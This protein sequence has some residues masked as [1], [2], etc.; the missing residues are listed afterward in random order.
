MTSPDRAGRSVG[1]TDGPGPAEPRPEHNLRRALAAGTLAALLGAA[2]IT[3]AAGLL[4][5]TAG[6]LVVALAIGRAVGLVVAAANG[7]G[8]RSVA[9]ALALALASVA[10]GQLGTWLV[11]RAEGGVLDL[12]PYLAETFGIL[13]P[14]ELA[15]AALAAWW[16]AR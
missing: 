2:A 12:G 11:A 6:L 13:V 1:P 4:A 8:R 15:F 14:L 3:V 5:L 9:T 16:T 7:R 10:L